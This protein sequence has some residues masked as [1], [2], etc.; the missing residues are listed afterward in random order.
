MVTDLVH[1]YQWWEADALTLTRMNTAR[2]TWTNLNMIQAEFGP[3]NMARDSLE[4]GEKQKVPY[5]KD[6]INFG[7]RLF[8]KNNLF[9]YTNSDSSLV[10][11]I[12][13]S[14]K[15]SLDLYSCGY[16]HRV[17]FEKGK[18][19]KGNISQDQLKNSLALGSWSGGSD[20]FFFTRDWWDRHA[21]D[22]PDALS[23]FE[24]WDACMM[25]TML[26]S[27][28]TEPVKWL[29]YH[30]RHKAYWKENRTKAIGQIYN[31]KVCTEWALKNNLG[32]LLGATEFLFKVP[33]PYNVVV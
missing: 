9:L 29:S 1:I 31:R 6:V 23:G 13:K 24:G 32:H 12:V 5:I 14:I 27:G 30:E 26:K 22:F 10:T 33:T 17:D 8:P 15:K 21:N 18:Y 7:L 25:A 3:I 2:R 16:S 11:D 28:L 19:P 4:Q 20:I